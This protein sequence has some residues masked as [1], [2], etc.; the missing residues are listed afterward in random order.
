MP[1]ELGIGQLSIGDQAAAIPFPSLVM[2]ATSIRQNNHR[3]QFV[4]WFLA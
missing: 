4:A 1:Q 2:L 3:F